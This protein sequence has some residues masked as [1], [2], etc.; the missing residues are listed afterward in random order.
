MA[1]PTMPEWLSKREGSLRHGLNDRTVFVFLGDQ[2][3][4]RLDVRPA[5]GKFGCAVTQTVNA[6]RL[7][8]DVTYATAADALSGGLEQLRNKLGW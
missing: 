3:Q 1:V 4:Y 6:R 2:P 8:D 7:D 5:G